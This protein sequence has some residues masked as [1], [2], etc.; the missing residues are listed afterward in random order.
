LQHPF[1]Q[2]SAA[3]TE[4]AGRR[5]PSMSLLRPKCIDRPCEASSLQQPFLHVRHGFP[6][7]H[8][9]LGISID[10]ARKHYAAG[11]V[12]AKNG[13]DSKMHSPSI[14]IWRW[15]TGLLPFAACGNCTLGPED[16]RRSRKAW[17]FSVTT[18][19]RLRE[20]GHIAFCYQGLWDPQS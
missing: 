17:A 3:R 1:H 16:C 20:P 6:A 7:V 19:M 10:L 8:V 5:A 12:F 13:P 4:S 14:N 15:P 9:H 18:C 11:L 2:P